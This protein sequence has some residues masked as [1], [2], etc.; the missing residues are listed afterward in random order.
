[1]CVACSETFLIV[2]RGEKKKKKIKRERRNSWIIL[3]GFAPPLKPYKSVANKITIQS[4]V[5]W[6]PFMTLLKLYA[7]C[8]LWLWRAFRS[9]GVD[10]DRV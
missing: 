4:D 2:S 3:F 9:L 6:A 8:V 1:M 10:Y 7:V 5:F